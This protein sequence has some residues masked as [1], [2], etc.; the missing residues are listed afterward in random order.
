MKYIIRLFKM[1]K[2]WA[3][4]IALAIIGML[5][6]T[7]IN[8]YTPLITKRVIRYIELG[9]SEDII[10]TIVKWC[11]L[12]LLFYLLRAL[13]K[14][15]NQYYGH[16][17]SWNLVAHV[18]T[19]LY[20]H[21]QK[22]SMRF[23]RDKQTGELMARVVSDTST[24][25]TLFAHAL[26]D[27]VSYVITFV[28]VFVILMT[29]NPILTLYTC[30][31]LPFV[32][33]SSFILR[34]MRRYF[35]KGQEMNAELSAQLQDNFSGMKEIQIFNKQQEE[36][37]NIREKSQNHANA[38]IRALFN[39]A[40]MHPIVEVLTSL[41]TVIVLILGSIYAY[42][43]GLAISE[44]VTFILYLAQFYA[45]VAGFARILEDLQ[46]GI[47]GAE[48]VF[49]VL[50]TEPEIKNAP[51]AV[52]VG[53]LTGE[54]TFDHVSFSYDEALPVLNDISFTANAGEML[55]IVGPTGEGKTTMSSLIARFYDPKEGSVTMDGVDLRKMTLESLRD[56]LSYVLQDV[57]L[58]NGSVHDNIAYAAP[59]VTDEQ[60]I[61]AA[62]TACIHDFIVSLPQGYDTQIGERGT[63]LSGGQKQRIAIARAILRDSPILVLDEATSAVDTETESNIQR[64]ISNIAGSRTIIVIAH[65][66]S[67]IKKANKILV[68]SGG[69]IAESGTHDELLAKK[70]KYFELCSDQKV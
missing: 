24:F 67:T 29:I 69:R 43:S 57:F 61:E 64:A 68:L 19:L 48:R 31:P 17:A 20:D 13:M 63:R 9:L 22:L 54:I 5:G 16:K 6:A 42:N 34:R 37:E 55:A 30:I 27:L 2:P 47:A 40:V 51:D 11:C 25:E 44:L 23:F 4:Y 10:I 66:L 49:Q 26:P 28:G 38:L 15:M 33:V 32:G 62:K 18:R 36:L 53:R 58:F 3:K 46:H 21:Y 65:R 56:N 60:I 8:L 70:G 12:L 39:S 1:T 45:P 41:G 50:D 52:D 7:A 35:R 59:G 14:F